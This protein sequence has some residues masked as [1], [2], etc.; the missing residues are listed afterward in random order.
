MLLDIAM[1]QK[2]I[3]KNKH[4]SKNSYT[5]IESKQNTEV[6]LEKYKVAIYA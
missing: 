3:L 1:E 6:Q 5:N 2:G 4:V